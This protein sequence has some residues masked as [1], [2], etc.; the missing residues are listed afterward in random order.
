MKREIIDLK[1]EHSENRPD[2]IDVITVADRYKKHNAHYSEQS[3]PQRLGFYIMMYVTEGSGEHAI[4][5]GRF[6]LFSAILQG[7]LKQKLHYTSM[8]MLSLSKLMPV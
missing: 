7:Y 8:H 1:F 2:G 5:P 6:D 4:T 3:L